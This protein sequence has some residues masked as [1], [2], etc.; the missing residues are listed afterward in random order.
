MIARVF[1]LIVV[2]ITSALANT[3]NNEVSES[4]KISGN[5]HRNHFVRGLGP[6]VRQ[7]WGE[8]WPE[9]QRRT[10]YGENFMVVRMAL[11]RFKVI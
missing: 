8:P 11:F 6:H 10:L 3:N 5:N 2:S 1:V 9:P 4:L 7:T